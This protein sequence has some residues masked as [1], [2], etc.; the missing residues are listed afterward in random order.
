MKQKDLISC[1]K[2]YQLDRK[3]SLIVE[4]NAEIKSILKVASQ[5]VGWCYLIGN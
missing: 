1:A 5:L 4:K 2:C 3:I